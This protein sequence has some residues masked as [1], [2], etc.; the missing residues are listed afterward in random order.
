MENRQSIGETGE[1]LAIWYLEGCGYRILERNYRN[2]LGEIDIVAREQGAIVFVEVKTRRSGRYGSPKE[3]VTR[4]KQ[5]GLSR[6]A[7]SYLKE[8]GQTASRARFDV[9]SIRYVEQMPRIELI[10]NAFDLAYPR[11]SE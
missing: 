8:T 6:V 3:A 1:N 4:K 7:L 2:R 10:K 5:E 9:V 11:R